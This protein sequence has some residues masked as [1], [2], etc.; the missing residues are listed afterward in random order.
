MVINNIKNI[1]VCYIN[2]RSNFMQCIPLAV[3]VV[4]MYKH[5]ALFVHTEY[6]IGRKLKVSNIFQKLWKFTLSEISWF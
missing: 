3:Q 6:S 2:S 1:H 5:F 4:H